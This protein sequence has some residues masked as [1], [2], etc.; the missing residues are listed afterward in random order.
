MDKAAL[1]TLDP[2]TGT[3]LLEALDDSKLAI[4]V[5]LWFNSAE[6]RIGVLF[7]P[8]V[9]WMKRVRPTHTGLFTT[10]WRKPGDL[11]RIFGKAKNVEGMRL[12]H[13]LIG[14]RFIEDALVYR[15]R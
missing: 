5:V 2:A 7:Y 10:P 12:G 9:V 11:R 4:S 8:R 1:V 3:K 15:I 14:N 13:Q 6:Y